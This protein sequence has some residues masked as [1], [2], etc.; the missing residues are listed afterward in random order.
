MRISSRNCK[1][2]TGYSVEMFEEI[3]I[4]MVFPKICIPNKPTSIIFLKID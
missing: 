2:F 4:F 1:K 3:I